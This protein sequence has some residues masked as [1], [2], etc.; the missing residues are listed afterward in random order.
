MFG[1]RQPA[2]T[3]PQRGLFAMFLS[4]VFGQ[5]TGFDMGKKKKSSKWAGIVGDI[6]NQQYADRIKSLQA[7]GL[8]TTEIEKTVEEAIASFNSENQ[9]SFVIFGEPQSGKTEMMIALNARLLDEGCDVI[10]NLLNDSVDLLNQSLSRF[11]LAGLNPSPKQFSDLPTDVR[12]MKGKRWVIFAK[13][14]ARDLA[15]LKESLRFVKR[16]VVIDDEADYASPN[17]KVNKANERTKINQLIHDL[18]KNR[19]RYIGVTATPARLDL[20]NTFD[21][22]TEKWVNFAPHKAYVG[23]DFFFPADG[24]VDY[25]LFPFAADEGNERT[26]LREA[27]FHFLCGVA[28]QH[29]KGNKE[30]F[31]MVV[32]TSGKKIEHTE[33]IAV[34]EDVVNTL[35]SSS[36]TKFESYTRMLEKVAKGYTSGNPDDVVEF[37]LRRIN[38]NQIVTVNSDKKGSN[39]VSSLLKP[40]SLFSFGAGGNIISR[41]ITFDNLLSMY[42]TRA[43]KGKFTQDTYIQRARMFGSRQAYKKSFQ[44]WIPTPLL[45]NWSKCFFFH[46]LAVEAIRAGKGAP[47]WLSDHKTAP[48]AAASI[49]RSSVDFEYGEMSFGQ[50]DYD[51]PEYLNFEKTIASATD[52]KLIRELGKWLGEDCF[53]AYVR[54][55]ILNDIRAKKQRVCFHKPSQFGKRAKTYTT[56]EIRN[57]RREKGIFS[58]NEFARGSVPEARHHLKIFFNKYGKARLLYKINGTTVRFIQN[59]K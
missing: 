58:T 1:Y 4:K 28:Q 54:S 16:L 9:D 13:K 51:E 36:S 44:L 19:G 20:N 59:R 56:A 29:Q 34:I 26:K 48:T 18:I 39:S 37:V 47:V 32:H 2:S 40:T 6:G 12:S 55:F 41:G 45:E 42:F 3:V 25:Q 53:P 49:D 30:N 43:V 33:D 46:K 10:I 35:S 15:K 21:N 5:E 8:K 27:I 31:T 50:F 17:A 22:D 14:N 11:Q 24:K 38:Q 7:S 52:D 57:I 23:Q